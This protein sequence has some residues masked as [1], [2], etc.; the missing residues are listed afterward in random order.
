MIDF[1]TESDFQKGKNC[2]L[3][4]VGFRGKPTFQKEKNH[5][6]KKIDPDKNFRR[7]Y[8]VRIFR[9]YFINFPAREKLITKKLTNL[10]N[11]ALDLIYKH[12]DRI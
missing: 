3:P 11:Y 4:E 1:G 6:L 8:P 12:I 5:Y 7:L 10:S 9:S 2:D